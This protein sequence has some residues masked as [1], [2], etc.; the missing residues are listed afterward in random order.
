MCYVMRQRHAF[1]GIRIRTPSSEKK[2]M[3]LIPFF[4]IPVGSNPSLL[5][6][7]GIAL[8]QFL[9]TS[10]VFPFQKVIL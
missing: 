10:P 5:S 9:P 6:T 8:I 7:Q 3:S 2:S 1:M 4:P